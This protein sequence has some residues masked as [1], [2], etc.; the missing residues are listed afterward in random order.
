MSIFE[1]VRARP[2][3][4]YR[5]AIVG[6]RR[7]HTLVREFLHTPSTL[8]STVFCSFFDI[9]SCVHRVLRAVW[10]PIRHVGWVGLPGGPDDRKVA[11]CINVAGERGVYSIASD[12]D[13]VR[14]K[15]CFWRG[16]VSAGRR[17]RALG[18][19]V[20]ITGCMN[21]PIAGRCKAHL[22]LQP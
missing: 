8:C 19:L 22:A 4:A 13:S 15:F 5:C 18:S 1:V 6:F 3:G 9:F 2:W 21:R 12:A 10:Y 11:R 17:M 16:S 20:H 7:E 14:E